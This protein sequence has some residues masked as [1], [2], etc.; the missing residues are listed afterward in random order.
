MIHRCNMREEIV[1]GI[2]SLDDVN[3]CAITS[4][5]GFI[6]EVSGA[7]SKFLEGTASL[8]PNTIENAASTLA[9]MKLGDPKIVTIVSE[10]GILAIIRINGQYSLVSNM[11]KGANLGLV[12]RKMNEGVT[13]LIPI[14]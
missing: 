14:L 4:S 11:K 1:K 10:E 6:E 2:A 9:N 12:R 7:P 3:W 8:L 13:N 5:E